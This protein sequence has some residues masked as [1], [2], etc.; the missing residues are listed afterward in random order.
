MYNLLPRLGVN[1]RS[2]YVSLVNFFFMRTFHFAILGALLI[3][4]LAAC[5]PQSIDS[6]ADAATVFAANQTDINNYVI[7]KGLS[8]T[9]SASGLFF[10]T[11]VPSSSTVIPTFGQE[12]EFNY[13]L[14][15]LNGQSNTGVTSTT[16]VTDKVV[17]SAYVTTSA[18]FPFFAG[19]LKSGLEEGIRKMHEGESA[20]LIMPS[21]LAFGN[22]ASSDK[23]IPANSPVRFDVTVRRAR[24]EDQQIDDYIAT[25][26][27][28]VTEKTPTGLR[29][30]KTKDNPTGATPTANQTITI[31]FAGKLLRATTGF[32]GGTGTDT[33]TVGVLKYV[34][35]FEEGLAKLRVGDKATVIFPSSLG[36]GATGAA[37]NQTYVIPP[38]SPLSFDLEVV[39]VK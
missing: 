21:L 36:Y 12:I 34:P 15:V 38:Y 14:Y 23:A 39:S 17:D 13:K 7:S 28:V 11:T 2:I 32:A 4:G 16:A 37:Q 29:F 8:G 6:N 20:I 1:G 31:N 27:L 25:N 26:K 18:Y 22:V 30:I 19:S 10:Q 9:T 24:T 5:Q 33:K 3:G 35:G